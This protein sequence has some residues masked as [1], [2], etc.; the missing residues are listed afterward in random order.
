ALR[1][2]ETA[3]VA[4]DSKT[5]VMMTEMLQSQNSQLNEKFIELDKTIQRMSDQMAM[6][7]DM[8]EKENEE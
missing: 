8:R 4:L 5:G 7:R 1:A 2:T 6:E 3:E